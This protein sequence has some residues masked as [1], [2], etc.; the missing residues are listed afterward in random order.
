MYREFRPDQRLRPFVEC[1]WLRSGSATPAVRVMPDGCVDIFVT[2]QGDVMIA[3]PANT[4]YDLPAD[5]QDILA[6][7]RLR[8]GAAAALIGCP[9]SEF[10]DMR[11][12]LSSAFGVAGSQVAESLLG[13]TTPGQRMSLLADLVAEYFADVDPV[14][15]RPVTRAVAVLRAHPDQ[16]GRAHV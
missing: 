5:Q 4:F 10:K 1:G 15:D 12:P 7:L 2:A 13:T 3:G 11:V 9:A 16:I 14:L 8:P 6:G